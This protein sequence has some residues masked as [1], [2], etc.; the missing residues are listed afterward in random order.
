MSANTPGKVGIYACGFPCTPYSALHS[1]SALLQ[2][3]NAKQM[4]QSIRHMV[5]SE[6]AAP[7]KTNNSEK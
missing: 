3:P 5:E 1:G 6:C 4:W 2:D 7:C